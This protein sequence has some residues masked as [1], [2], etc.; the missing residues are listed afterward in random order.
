[1]S[2]RSRE[3]NAKMDETHLML[4]SANYGAQIS[5]KN[6]ALKKETAPKISRDIAARKQETSAAYLAVS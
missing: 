3:V 6:E 5:R 4:N 2:P 1:M